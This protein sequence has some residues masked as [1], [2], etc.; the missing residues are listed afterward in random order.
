MAT[1]ITTNNL[2]LNNIKN[3]KKIKEKVI[4]KY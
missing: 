1:I 3:S 2:I 4:L